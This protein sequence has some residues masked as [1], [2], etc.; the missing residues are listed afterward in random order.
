[1]E[2]RNKRKTFILIRG[3]HPASGNTSAAFDP[4]A[5]FLIGDLVPL[6]DVMYFQG[7]EAL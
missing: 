5:R 6:H 3:L 1:M 7:E 4:I 2:E